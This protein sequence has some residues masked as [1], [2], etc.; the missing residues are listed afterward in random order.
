MADFKAAP[1]KPVDLRVDDPDEGVHQDEAVRQGGRASEVHA[2][3]EDR[4]AEHGHQQ[5]LPTV[6]S[7]DGALRR[8]GRL[9]RGDAQQGHH[10]LLDL[11]QGFVQAGAH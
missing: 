8:G 10:H 1:L 11:H 5:H 6:L 7:G 3:L 2:E 4:G 9:F